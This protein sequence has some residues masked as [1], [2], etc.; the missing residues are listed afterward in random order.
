MSSVPL[1]EDGNVM[2]SSVGA[3]K[4]YWVMFK[5]LFE[6]FNQKTFAELMK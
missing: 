1:L 2:L 6:F 4:V 5:V 3:G